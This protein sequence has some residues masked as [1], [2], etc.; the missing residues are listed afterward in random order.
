[1][2]DKFIVFEWSVAHAGEFFS[3]AWSREVKHPDEDGFA[4]SGSNHLGRRP[5]TQ[6]QFDCA[7]NQTFAC[8]G[9]S[10]K[11]I[12]RLIELHLEFLNDRQIFD[13]QFAEHR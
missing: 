3:H 7:D 1:L 12:K 9:L 8:P 11:D 2:K 4:R 10:G 13:V 5:E 6:Q